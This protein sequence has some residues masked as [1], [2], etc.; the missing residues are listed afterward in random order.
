MQMRDALAA[1]TEAVP[2]PG[3]ANAGMSD[4]VQPIEASDL[5]ADARAVIYCRAPTVVQGPRR[6]AKEW[7]LEFE[8][9]GKPFID[10]LMGWT[11]GTDTLRQIK[12][13]FPTLEAAIGYA[14]RQGLRYEVHGPTSLNC[15]VAAHVGQAEPISVHVPVEGAWAWD[16]PHLALEQLLVANDAK[17]AAT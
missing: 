5:P 11:G 8:P 13:R 15:G 2:F 12:L 4:C 7:I 16:V 6:R 14:C 10:P 1:R 3:T 17:R 9:R